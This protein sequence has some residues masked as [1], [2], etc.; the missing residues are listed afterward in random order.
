MEEIDPDTTMLAA[1]VVIS[2][3]AL[4]EFYSVRKEIRERRSHGSTEE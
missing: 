2:M 4:I 3:I 1:G